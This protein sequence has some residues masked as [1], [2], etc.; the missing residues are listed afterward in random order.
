[1]SRKLQCLA[2]FAGLVMTASVASQSHAQVMSE[3]GTRYW[4]STGETAFDLFTAVGPPI[5]S[6]L[7]YDGLDAHS[8]EIFG[9][10]QDY[11]GTFQNG[12]FVKGYAGIGV[13]PDG[14]L[15]DEDFP[16]FI[17]PY[18]N[19]LSQ[20][21]DGDLRYFN[22]DA[23]TIVHKGANFEVGVF[24]G[25]HYW[26]EDVHAFG[27]AQQALSL[28]CVPTIPGTVA[29]I[30][31]EVTWHS[32][33]LGLGGKVMLGERFSLSGEAAWVPY[34]RLDNVDRHHLRPPINPLPMDGDG[35]GV[36]LEAIANFYVNPNFAIGLG[37]RYWNLS[38]DGFARFD[39]TP[40]GGFPQV[41]ELDSERYGVF[42]EAKVK[43]PNGN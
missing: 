12:W 28:I 42:L 13:I 8:G 22:L 15:V 38:A 20:L 21:D 36:M 26:N 25:Y 7:T 3:I 24:L 37:A 41:I 6:R 17:V 23:G 34:A 35:Q 29:V 2:A 19:T 11:T 32:L 30:S 39:Q 5:V 14:T 31:N 1:M 10:I 4:Y 33:R 43:L 16:P 40:G 27:C 18:S 9:K